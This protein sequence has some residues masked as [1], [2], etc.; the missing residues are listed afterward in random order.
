MAGGDWDIGPDCV[1]CHTVYFDVAVRMCVICAAETSCCS[2]CWHQFPDAARELE[3]SKDKDVRHMLCMD[4]VTRTIK[5][6]IRCAWRSLSDAAP[7][8]A[9]R[10]LTCHLNHLLRQTQWWQEY[11]T[12]M[13][14]LNLR[15]KFTV[16]GAR[17][18]ANEIAAIPETFLPQELLYSVC[19]ALG[20][21]IAPQHRTD[22]LRVL[23]AP[24][25]RGKAGNEV[26][27][28][29]WFCRDIACR[30]R[31]IQPRRAVFD[32]F[33]RRRAHLLKTVRARPLW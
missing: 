32:L 6:Y 5:Q 15:L 7:D 18:D 24:F 21:R 19:A 20:V 1:E 26:L 12:G 11:W 16:H 13:V 27:L 33:R 2:R 28:P 4:M 23:A 22:V 29:H 9:L 8:A 30:V 25:Q 17:I 31:Q 14:A 3:H 10:V